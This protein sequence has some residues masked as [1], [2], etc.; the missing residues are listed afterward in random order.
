MATVSFSLS[1]SDRSRLARFPEGTCPA[2]F[3]ICPAKCRQTN[4]PRWLPVLSAALGRSPD[5]GQALLQWVCLLLVLESNGISDGGHRLHC[6]HLA[7]VSLL[8][9]MGQHSAPNH[10]S[11]SKRVLAANL[12]LRGAHFARRKVK[13]SRVLAPST[14]VGE[15][16]ALSVDRT[17]G[18]RRLLSCCHAELHYLCCEPGQLL[19]G[20]LATNDEKL[21]SKPM[22]SV[23]STGCITICKTSATRAPNRRRTVS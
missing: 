16:N 13:E 4:L 8:L 15:N 19:K 20:S 3:A 18:Q 17:A 12:A 1:V 9:Q 23:P 6:H 11:L 22:S 14:S 10:S 5:P 21:Q 2:S 7:R